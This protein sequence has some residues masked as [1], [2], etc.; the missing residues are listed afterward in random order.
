VRYFLVEFSIT[1]QACIVRPF[2]N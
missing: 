1:C 2:S